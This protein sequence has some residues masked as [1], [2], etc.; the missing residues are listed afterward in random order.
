MARENLF[1]IEAGD[2]APRLAEANAA[3]VARRDAI[4]AA[5]ERVP[6][7]LPDADAAARAFRFAGQIKA[8]IAETRSTKT[9]DCGPLRAAQKAADGFF[10]EVSRPLQR[11]LARVE[12]LLTRAA[13]PPPPVA[14][15]PPAMAG[16]AAPEVVAAKP[17]PPAVPVAA[18]LPLV[19]KAERVNRAALDLE[20]LREH[21]TDTELDRAVAR[22]L[23]ANGPGDLTGV[24]WRQVVEAPRNRGPA[25]PI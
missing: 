13:A 4:L 14:A 15:T 5:L 12:A 2:V 3:L 18:N 20:A 25:E 21:F 1:G 24:S 23:D 22:W 11:A 19:W 7:P 10:E 16:A 17:V 6:D 9:A 8:A